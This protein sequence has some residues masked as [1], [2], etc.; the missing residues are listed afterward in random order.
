[1]DILYI[2]IPIS[3]IQVAVAVGLFLW[4]VRRDQFEDYQGPAE[5]ILLD[6]DLEPGL[7]LDPQ[8]IKGKNPGEPPP[9]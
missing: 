5:Q 2:L 6:L 8:E 1:M 4:A 9:G 7:K 3:L